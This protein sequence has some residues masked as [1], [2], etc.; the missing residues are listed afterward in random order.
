MNHFPWNTTH[1]ATPDDAKR[2][3]E[4]V[5]SGTLP[6]PNLFLGDIEA[7]FQVPTLANDIENEKRALVLLERKK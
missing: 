2:I 5:F 3:Q 7:R 1:I 4:K 6:S